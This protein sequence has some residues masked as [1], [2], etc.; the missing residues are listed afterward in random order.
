LSQRSKDIGA[1][2]EFIWEDVSS[3]GFERE[4]LVNETGLVSVQFA[5]LMRTYSAAVFEFL[6]CCESL[7]RMFPSVTPCSEME[8]IVYDELRMM[9]KSEEAPVARSD[10]KQLMVEVDGR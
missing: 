7:S 1:F 5:L 2:V 6:D 10:G 8:S 4:L 3:V 9:I